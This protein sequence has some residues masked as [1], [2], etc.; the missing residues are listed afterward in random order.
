M[1]ETVEKLGNSSSVSETH[2]GLYGVHTILFRFDYIEITLI[3]TFLSYTVQV[4]ANIKDMTFIAQ[5]AGDVD[6]LEN[7]ENDY[8]DCLMTLLLTADPSQRLIICPDNHGNISH[9]TSSM[10]NH[11]PW[12]VEFLLVF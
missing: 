4:N 10:N 6:Y 9:I 8:C 11:I 12:V 5:F 2:S 3:N 1:K 7:R